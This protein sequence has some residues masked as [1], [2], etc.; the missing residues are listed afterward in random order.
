[1]LRRV[2]LA[3]SVECCFCEELGGLSLEEGRLGR[4]IPLSF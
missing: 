3:D 2:D 1:M 4:M